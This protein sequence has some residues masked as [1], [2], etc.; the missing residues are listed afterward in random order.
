MKMLF[1]WLQHPLTRGLDLDDPNTTDLR[2]QVLQSKPFLWKIYQEWYQMIFKYIPQKDAKILEIGSGAG[3]SSHYST[4]VV[5]TDILHTRGIDI[6]CN[7]Q[8]L[9]FKDRSFQSL[10]MVNVLHHLHDTKQFLEETSRCL[11]DEGTICMVEPWNTRWASYFYKHF[12]HE[13]F[14]P[15]S[16]DWGCVD[17]GPLSSSNQAIPWIIFSR[18]VTEFSRK[19][20]EF[21][22]E[23]IR[24][25]MPIVY[26]ISGG[27]SLRN[28]VPAF[29]Y[30]FLRKIEHIFEGRQGL[31]ALIVIRKKK[32]I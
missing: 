31:F 7:G 32:I 25:I 16:R 13:P 12:H 3:F 9:P 8:H 30:P 17:G 2:R 26:V 18:D 28:L 5:Q 15:T 24:P 14:D 23:V 22:V 1:D 10:I 6:Q 4:K 11:I 21:T 19:Y 27:I 20:P 29:I